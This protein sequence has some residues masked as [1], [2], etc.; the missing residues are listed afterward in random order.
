MWNATILF[1]SRFTGL[2][3]LIEN[4]RASPLSIVRYPT[5]LK[6]RAYWIAYGPARKVPHLME[7]CLDGRG[8]QKW[9]LM[10]SQWVAT[11]GGKNIESNFIIYF[12][13]F[14]FVILEGFDE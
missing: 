8:F 11:V 13:L 14:F 4:E 7:M 1:R 5:L 6:K 9:H 2:T 12:S 10:G 3:P